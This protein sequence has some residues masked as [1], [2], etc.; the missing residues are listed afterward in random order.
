MSIL[1]SNNYYLP[2]GKITIFKQPEYVGYLELD[3]GFRVAFRKKP[4]WF[5]RKMIEL[6]FGWIWIDGKL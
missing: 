2:E 3:P 1:E 5:N 4:N 6:V